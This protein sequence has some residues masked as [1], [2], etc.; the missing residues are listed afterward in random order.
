MSYMNNDERDALR[1]DIERLTREYLRRGNRIV[2]VPHGVSGLGGNGMPGFRTTSI[3][4]SVEHSTKR[5]KTKER[6]A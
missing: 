1:K 2:E 6:Q 5:K 3:D 4:F